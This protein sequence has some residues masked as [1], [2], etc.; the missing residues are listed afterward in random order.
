M[1]AFFTTSLK[2]SLMDD[3]VC[4]INT[5]IVLCGGK[6]N[7]MK[8]AK[9][10]LPFG[11]EM[12]LQRVV[13]RVLQEVVQVVVVAAPRQKLPKLPS[14]VAVVRDSVAWEGPLQGFYTGLQ[15]G[16]SH[17]GWVFLTGC[18]V[19]FLN[20]DLIGLLKKYLANKVDAVV[21]FLDGF[22]HPLTALYRTSLLPVVESLL[23]RGERRFQTLFEHC[24]VLPVLNNELRMVDPEL[25]SFES[26]NTPFAYRSALKKL[27]EQT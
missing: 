15:K 25:L 1:A 11:D 8:R 23:I 3:F 7:R 16:V 22:Y 18:D 2:K 24:R 26:M 10:R 17:E 14:Y 27:S 21:P 9:A 6:S 12:L 5:G 19:P 4:H 20:P 13:H